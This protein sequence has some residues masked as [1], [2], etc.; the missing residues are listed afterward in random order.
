MSKPKMTISSKSVGIGRRRKRD[1]RDAQPLDV[2]LNGGMN[3]S[4]SEDCTSSNC[5][6]C[7]PSAVS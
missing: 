6:D 2:K 4:D 7:L 1:I 3:A 5:G